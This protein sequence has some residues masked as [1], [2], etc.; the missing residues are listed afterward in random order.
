MDES[1]PEYLDDLA[2]TINNFILSECT[3]EPDS[4]VYRFR[5]YE[6]FIN[7]T[8]S[9]VQKKEFYDIMENML[10][11]ERYEKNKGQ[12]YVGIYHKIANKQKRDIEHRRKYM[13]E[14]H[15][16]TRTTSSSKSLKNSMELRQ[17]IIS[18][19]GVNDIIY[20]EII[21][22]G[23][24]R[25][26]YIRNLE[27]GERVRDWKETLTVLAQSYNEAKFNMRIQCNRN[28][29]YLSENF[30][31]HLNT[32]EEK[33]NLIPNYVKTLGNN[34]KITH[35]GTVTLWN[36]R[37]FIFKNKC[38]RSLDKFELND[39]T[40]THWINE[41]RSYLNGEDDSSY[42]IMFKYRDISDSS[43]KDIDDANTLEINIKL[44]NNMKLYYM[45]QYSKNMLGKF[46]SENEVPYYI[47]TYCEVQL[48]LIS[49]EYFRS[50]FNIN[51][52]IYPKIKPIFIIINK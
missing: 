19:F 1:T 41:I 32:I 12:Q 37:R 38:N 21:S 44:L 16:E 5:L 31:Y 9:V 24:I 49:P 10:G 35:Y 40:S 23:N 33:Y 50:C 27:T 3:L 7:S 39:K 36:E 25:N 26:R 43:I 47:K 2:V 30:D 46:T 28:F 14:Y 4:K 22:L 29:K 13:R 8:K 52:I 18:E 11:Y 34:L 15:M 51:R 45:K 48:G 6:E 42:C 20:Q 17:K